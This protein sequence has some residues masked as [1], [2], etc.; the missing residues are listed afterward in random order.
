MRRFTREVINR[1]L[2][3]ENFAARTPR[4]FPGRF[5]TRIFGEVVFTNGRKA[6]RY[7]G[8]PS[9]TAVRRLAKAAYSTGKHHC[10]F[11]EFDRRHIVKHS[12]WNGDVHYP[13]ELQNATSTLCAF[14]HPWESLTRH[15]DGLFGNPTYVQSIGGQRC[16]SPWPQ[17]P[18]DAAQRHRLWLQERGQLRETV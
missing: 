5:P 9:V 16:Y 6:V 3:Q 17:V 10:T 11:V 2:S 4:P 8:K 15:I 18:F 1:L 12:Y 14:Y 13:F 7:I